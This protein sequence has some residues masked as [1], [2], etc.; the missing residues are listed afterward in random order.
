MG[1]AGSSPVGIN[2]PFVGIGRAII[3]IDIVMRSARTENVVGMKVDL[4]IVLSFFR[5]HE[6]VSK[7]IDSKSTDVVTVAVFIGMFSKD[8]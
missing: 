6:Y 2:I 7:G 4:K 5:F 1:L 3:M 8:K